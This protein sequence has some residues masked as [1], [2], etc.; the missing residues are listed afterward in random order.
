MTGTITASR[1]YPMRSIWPRL[2]PWTYHQIVG[3]GK[4]VAKCNIDSIP[5]EATADR[6]FFVRFGT[7]SAL[8]IPLFVGQSV[9]HIFSVHSVTEECRW[10][11][12]FITSLRLLGEI[13]VGALERRDI[14]RSLKPTKHGWIWRQLPPAPDFGNLILQ[15]A[16][17]G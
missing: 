1:L 16:T 17:S 6:Q 13:F 11:E 5:A 12:S 2:L 8:A 3:L 15:Q 14:L 7:K 10:P 4:T 9:H